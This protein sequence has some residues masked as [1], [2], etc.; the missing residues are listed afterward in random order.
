MRISF[1]L[2]ALILHSITSGQDLMRLQVPL[3]TVIGTAPFSSHHRST[4]LSADSTGFTGMPPG[5]KDYK[6]KA[7]SLRPSDDKLFIFYGIS[8]SGKRV[9]IFDSNFDKNFSKEKTYVYEY[10]IRYNKALEK[11]IIDTTS[12][13]ALNFPN[14]QPIFVKPNILNCCSSYMNRIDSIWHMYIETGYHREGV[15]NINDKI[16]R[17]V[18]SGELSPY[19]MRESTDFFLGSDNEVFQEQNDNNQPYKLKQTIFVENRDFSIDSVNKFGDTAWILYKGYNQKPIGNRKGLYAQNIKT[20]TLDKNEFNLHRLNGKY[21]LLD[22]W[23]TWC[24]PCIELIP[25]L[26]A[27]N[28]RYMSKGLALVS[29]ANENKDSYKS[30]ITMTGDKQMNWTNIYDDR[31]LKNN[32]CEQFD[33]ECYP[34][35][36]LIDKSGK[37]IF[38][39]CGEADFEQLEELLGRLLK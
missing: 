31:D 39:A 8:E 29:I 26:K 32:I 34:T 13:V 23:G 38:R 11:A 6:I 3:K 14:S 20:R 27:L 19:F 37:I 9:I 21:V 18:V 2:F 15:F 22:F 7:L 10:D 24:N 5:L 25:K 33:I 12:F 16:F 36:I 1:L 35:S 4:D 17:M 30:L 28:S